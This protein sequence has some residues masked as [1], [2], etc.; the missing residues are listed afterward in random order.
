MLTLIKVGGQVIDDEAKLAAFL[1]D[2]AALEGP[3]V[4]VHGGGKL[5]SALMR[6]LGIEPRMVDGRRITDADTLRIVTMTYAGW[7]GKTIAARL[8]ALGCRA[9]SLCGADA[10][11]LPSVRRAPAPIDFGFVG[12]PI[13]ERIDP[14][15]VLALMEAGLVPVIAP[16]TADAEGQLLNTNADTVAAVLA[17]ALARHTRVRLFLAF[18]KDGVLDAEGNVLPEL[19]VDH[20]RALVASGVVKD[21]MRPK[22]DGGFNALRGGVEEVLIGGSDDVPAVLTGKAQATRLRLAAMPTP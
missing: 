10:A 16:I 19:T 13:A 9:V 3:K 4:L 21:G 17:S 8:N 20:T 14:R 2:F 7:I 22:L 12:D 11:L 15:V 1:R 18:E 5:A 6:S